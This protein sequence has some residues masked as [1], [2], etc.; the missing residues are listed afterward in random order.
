M[1]PFTITSKRIKHPGINLPKEAKDLYSKN[2]KMLMKEIKDDTN[3]QKD[4]TIF[5]YWKNL[6]CQNDY[7]TQGNLQ[8][9]CNSYQITN[10]I[11]QKTRT[12]KFL[13]CMETQKTQNSQS[14]PEK[15]KQRWRNQT[16]LT[17]DHTTKLQS[18]KQYGTTQK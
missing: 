3:R 12:K 8:I 9:Q 13:M 14:S 2:C 15:E 4:N 18:Q 1:I 16:P 7:I 10:G 11:F 5:L 6:Y 17:S